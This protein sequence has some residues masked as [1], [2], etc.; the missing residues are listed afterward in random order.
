MSS[1]RPI[2]PLD[3][4]LPPA[5]GPGEPRPPEPRRSG[6]FYLVGIV[7]FAA[8][9]LG[10][11]GIGR[12]RNHEARDD[13]QSRETEVKQGP[14]VRV[15]TV[16]QASSIRHLSLQ[17]EARPYFE[18]TLYAKVAGFLSDLKVDK[19]DRV[20][21]NQLIAKVTAPELD[22]QYTAA[23]ADAKNKRVNAKRLNALAPAGVV[24]AQELELGQAN[25]DVADATQSAIATQRG[26]RVIRAPFDGVISARFADPG[27]LI[28]SAANAQSGA[29]PIVSVSKGDQLRVWVYVDQSSAPFVH[30]GDSAVVTVP[31][32]PG[33]SRQAKIART[34]G[35]LSPRT[36]TMLT[37]VDISNDD[38]LIVPGSYVQVTLDVRIPPLLEVPAEAL[39]TRNDKPAVA[40]LDDTGHVHYKPVVVASDDG[41]VVRLV[42]GVDANTRVAL[43]LGSSVQDGGPVQVVE[44]KPPGGA[45]PGPAR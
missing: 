23:V 1:P 34:S 20:K 35:Q 42:S 41:Q 43:D 16:K 21:K 15:A 39:V 6:L 40:V 10:V 30:A 9:V 7:V 18:V 24:S 12:H 33:W 11:V 25:A 13:A 29:V 28:Q 45:S 17:G 36:R 27:T 38:H 26:Y 22:A 14:R 2:D 31:E 4:D 8:T 44:A 19:G 5:R 3:D 32:R 37:E